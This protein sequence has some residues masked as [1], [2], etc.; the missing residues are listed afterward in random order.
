MKRILKR[1]PN[2]GKLIFACIDFKPLFL[3]TLLNKFGKEGKFNS[4][5]VA[6]LF[7]HL[8]TL[9]SCQMRL[10]RLV[11]QNYLARKRIYS[12]ELKS[13]IYIY[14]FSRISKEYCKYWVGFNVLPDS[15]LLKNKA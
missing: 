4:T 5:D 13:F 1:T 7:R 9:K 3:Q 11:R 8:C 14:S 10:L 12:E 6:S 15:P 2:R